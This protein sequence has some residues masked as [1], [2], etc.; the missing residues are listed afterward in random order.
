M[1]RTSKVLYVGALLIF[2]AATMRAS[3]VGTLNTFTPGTTI[4]STAIND[5]FAALQAAVDDNA[6]TKVNLAGDTMTGP[7]TVPTVQYSAP[8]QHSVTVPAEAFTS[9]QGQPVKKGLGNGEAYIS[10]AGFGG[11]VAPLYVPDGATITGFTA[12]LKDSAA[13]DLQI[14]AYMHSLGG[15]YGNIGTVTST[16][17]S[18]VQPF[19]SPALAHV[20]QYQSSGYMIMAYSSAWPG[21]STLAVMGVRVDYTLDEAP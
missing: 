20:V 6:T 5:N 2:F 13:G 7:L 4:S 15:G 14:V 17:V 10:A 11:I 8:R 16:N 9:R 1:R 21:D 19:D 3:T 18:G 12:Y